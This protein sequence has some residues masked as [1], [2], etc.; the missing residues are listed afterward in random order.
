MSVNYT[1]PP[2]TVLTPLEIRIQNLLRVL[3][4]MEPNANLIAGDD[5]LNRLLDALCLKI[6]QSSTAHAS[7]STKSKLVLVHTIQVNLDQ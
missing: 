2:H 5:E 3:L 1:C 4:P 6:K 7:N